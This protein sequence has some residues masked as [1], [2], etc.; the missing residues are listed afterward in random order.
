MNVAETTLLPEAI[1]LAEK[2]L[3]VYD[4]REY[5]E[6]RVSASS[7]FAAMRRCGRLTF[8]VP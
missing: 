6:T 4:V 3:P 1:S 8:A 7:F 5:H 2:F